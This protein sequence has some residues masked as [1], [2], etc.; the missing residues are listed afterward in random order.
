M[1]EDEADA[2]DHLYAAMCTDII[3]EI[4]SIRT[5]EEIRWHIDRLIVPPTGYRFSQRQ[6]DEQYL[7]FKHKRD[8]LPISSQCQLYRSTILFVCE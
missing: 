8:L 1:K 4:E 6:R 5:D 7:F 3:D 2:D